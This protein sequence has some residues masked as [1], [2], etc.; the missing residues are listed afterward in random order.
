MAQTVCSN[1]TKLFG[2]E[3]VGYKILFDASNVSALNQNKT[4]HEDLISK[5]LAN[6][7]KLKQMNADLDTTSLTTEIYNSYG[8]EK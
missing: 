3:K 7:E 2:L 4:E 1:L 6:I 5:R 8:N